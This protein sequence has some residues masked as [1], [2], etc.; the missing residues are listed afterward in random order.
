MKGN[1][2]TNE[3]IKDL[4]KIILNSYQ[5]SISST[6]Q[7]VENVFRKARSALKRLSKR[8]RKANI[9]M[10]Y[11]DEMGLAEYSPNNPLKVIHAELEYDQNKGRKKIA[12]VGISNWA[13][14]ASKMNRGMYLSIP[15]PSQ[16]DTKETAFTIGKSYDENVANQYKY[17]FEQLGLTYFKYKNYL[18][19]REKINLDGKEDFYGNRDFY[20]LIKNA[21]RNVV[22]K[23]K[24]SQKID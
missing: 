15:E 11:F 5:G 7:G 17:F 24:S 22:D 9:S 6:S 18:K 8:D 4:P 21:T 19:E 20:H 12:F 23:F 3:N 10:I 13:L 14:D 2:T 16:E 1:S